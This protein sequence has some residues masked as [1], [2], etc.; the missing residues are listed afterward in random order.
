MSKREIFNDAEIGLPE[1]LSKIGIFAVEGDQNI[2]GGAIDYPAHWADFAV[3]AINAIEI[4]IG[5]GRL[6]KGDKL[7]DNDATVTL[8]LQTYL[9]LVNNDEKWI[10][11]LVRGETEIVQEQRMVEIDVDSEET[12]QQPL[13]KIERYKTTFTVQQ[14]VAS[15]TP[16]KPSVPGDEC[17]LCYV[18][19]TTAGIAELEIAEDWRVQTLYDINGR[20]TQ[21]EGEMVAV[22]RRTSTLET[23]VANLAAKIKTIPRPEIIRQMQRDIAQTRRILHLPAAA[24]A[25]WY[26]AGLI[27]ADWATDH[28][29][30]LARIKEGVRFAYAAESDSQLA[31]LEPL[32]PLLSTY[33][34]MVT[35]AYDEVVRISVVGSDGSKNISQLTH[36]VTTAVRREV[37]RTSV[38][39]GPTIAICE[40]QA[41]WASV[42]DMRVGS[43][44]AVGGETFVYQ[45]EI[46]NGTSNID[47]SVIRQWNPTAT[48]QDVAAWNADPQS[49]GHKGYAVQQIQ[50]DSWTDVYWDYVTESVGVNGSVYA[51]TFLNAQPM[52]ATSIDL[53]FTRIGVQTGDVHL[54][55]CETGATGAP[56]F[57]RVIARTTVTQENLALG[58]TKFR[59]RPSLLDAGK[60]YAW[61]VVTT[62]NH[63]IATVGVAGNDALANKYAQGSLFWSTDGVWSQG[64]PQVDFAF[65]LNAAKFK[66]TRTV[67]EFSPLTLSG[68]MTQINLKYAGWAP[69]GTRMVWEIQASGETE[70]STLT[71]TSSLSDNQL[72]GLPAL[73][74]LRLTMVGTTDLAPAI[75]MD[76]KA[77]GIAQRHRTDMK[78]VSKLHQFGVTSETIQYEVVVDNFDS[79]HHTLVNKLYIAGVA[80]APT[81]T[82]ITQDA[83]KP[84]RWTYLST[85][86]R[87]PGNGISSARVRTDMTTDSALSVPFLQNV[88]FYVI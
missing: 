73:T 66:A 13:P 42:G 1:D 27:A 14:G 57:K 39:Y 55:L 68:G 49:T 43:A 25:Y 24:R 71:P 12:Q 52:I 44:F 23:D 60:L 67:M 2:I 75:V 38:S 87:T 21:L 79:N 36:T 16:T 81:S 29:D 78:C 51:Q 48:V 40:N 85:W 70:W 86:V 15:I 3:A 62:G 84:G 77:R 72:Y 63:A 69:E 45:G 83:V 56:D 82:V 35:P 58:W 6:F 54:M 26:D 76:N 53:Y 19:L 50:Y 17:C 65:R 22:K 37:A 41:E 64:D 59:F 4:E 11:I 32:S 5:Q 47:M 88:A 18:R 61:F 46:T 10:A 33:D 34:S 74:R 7:Y 30:W 31:L 28:A 8:D 20:V 9:P 80:T